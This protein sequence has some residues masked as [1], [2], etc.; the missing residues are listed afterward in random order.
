MGIVFKKLLAQLLFWIYDFI[1]T[2]GTIFN[3]LTGTQ[4]VDETRTLLEVF[5]ESAVSTKIL[6]GLCMISIII[7]GVCMGVRTVKNII[8]L[9]SGGEQPS[10]ATTVRL[11]FIS[12]VSS[13]ACIFFIVLV[14]AF[15][16]MLLNM[17]NDVIAP[18]E[19]MTLSQNLFN[20][21]VEESYVVDE[22][23]WDSRLV[24]CYDENGNKIQDTDNEG[25]L[26]WDYDD[27]GGQTPIWKMREEWFHPYKYEDGQIVTESG[28]V[29]HTD[30]CQRRPNGEYYETHGAWCLSWSLDPDEVFGIH[31]KDWIG[32]FEQEDEGYKVKPMVRL[33]SFNMFTAYLVAIVVFISMFMLSVGLVK[34]IYDIIVL[35]MCA[36]LICGTIPLDEGARFKA[37]RETFMSKLL[38]AFGAVISLNVFYM[39]SRFITSATLDLSYLTEAGILSASGVSVFTM[40]LLLGGALC[41]NGSQVLIARIL[42]TS[43]DESREA[44]QSLAMISSG[45]RFGAAG[46]LGA[47]R[48]AMGAKRAVFGGTN[49]YGRERTGLVPTMFRGI[50]AIGE[51]RGGDA[52]T[53]SRGA[54]FVRFLGRMGRKNSQNQN[55]NGAATGA[56]GNAG[57]TNAGRIVG[58]QG[59]SGLNKPNVGGHINNSA[60]FV[61]GGLGGSQ[62]AN[63]GRPGTIAQPQSGNNSVSKDKPQSSIRPTNGGLRTS[64]GGNKAS[65]YNDNNSRKRN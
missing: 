13:V 15:M 4:S 45:V 40:L 11:G 63:P 52:Y 12:V 62:N 36:P 58:H 37:W 10:H 31:N 19:N 26:L 41:M 25:N 34:R 49:R 23:T 14:V 65:A 48:V 39:V 51:K 47:G 6:L 50:N 42:G 20:L 57:N 17:V 29:E 35:M 60:P 16:T 21:S 32:M 24:Y 7:A 2:I 5:V 33:E 28:W 54:A 9:K 3:I 56:G 30:S 46:A 22:D 44:M 59:L 43:A 8:R 64:N 18:E 27:N 1:D 61:S 53:Q 38:V 55:A